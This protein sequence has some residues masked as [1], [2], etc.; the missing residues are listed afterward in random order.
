MVRTAGPSNARF[1]LILSN[2]LSLGVLDSAGR[3]VI[4]RLSGCP[5]RPS[6]LSNGTNSINQAMKLNAKHLS[7][8]RTTAVHRFRFYL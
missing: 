2:P 5:A 6:V 1:R 7:Q 8:N 4:L 3:R